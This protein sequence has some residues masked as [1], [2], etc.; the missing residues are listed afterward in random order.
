MEKGNI[1]VQTENIFP[2]IKKFLY[3]DQEIFLRE[4]ISNAVDATKKL[5]A[6]VSIGDFKGELG[7]LTIEVKLDEKNKTLSVIDK[8]I[9]MTA[10]E[11]KKYI[12]Q[13]AFSS[14]EDFVKKFKDKEEASTELIGHFGLGFYSG[15]MVADKV[16]LVTQSYKKV[17]AAKWTCDGSPAYTLDKH[18]KKDRGTEVTLYISDESKE[19][20]DKVRIKEL[21]KKYC[22]FLPVEIKFDG[23]IINNTTPA[24]TKKPTELT[25]QDYK[26]F[27]KELYPYAEEPLFWIHLNVDHPFWLTGILY[28]PKIKSTIEPQK[29][30]IQLYSNQVFV[31]DSVEGI[32]PEFLTLLHGVMDSPDI[33]LNVSRSFLQ[34]DANV[35]KINSHIMKK[36]ADKL[37][38][39]YKKDRKEYE[40]KWKD[41]GLF[42]KYGML[43]EEKFYER[44]NKFC[45]F[46][47]TE[48]KYFTIEEYKSKIKDAQTDKDKKL[49]IL[50]TTNPSEQ[51]SFIEA[52]RNKGYDVL[53]FDD[54]LD[55][56]FVG[57]LE[58]KFEDISFKRVDADT[59]DKLIDKDEK[60][61][62]AL[63]EK[64]KEQLKPI[65]EKQVN[66]SSVAILFE[67]LSEK[68]MPMLITKPESIRRM[69]DMAAIQGM[70]YLKD[71][72]EQFNL[73]VNTNHRLINRILIE[74]TPSNQGKLIKQAYDLAL[75]SQNMLQGADLTEFVNRSVE[76]IK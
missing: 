22:K 20:L 2:I 30:K 19:Y 25:S 39:L 76:L 7:E 13:I 56:H 68:D 57:F 46:R 62:S 35:K 63:T 5:K 34:S 69:K 9:G 52:A 53:Q 11:V 42:I 66:N 43:S 61:K 73:V 29:N 41:I 10:D 45:L 21:L 71:M 1:A 48:E 14:A 36:V 27:Y 50:Y 60:R 24:W 23:T 49:V 17:P 47:N 51:H 72:P 32:V 64:Q 12:N 28:F 74:K 65:I 33:P 16:E 54:M 15:F 67:G 26:N 38:E 40:E 31:T 75:I 44:A 8:G 3:S 55:S 6:L 18:D 70:D 4:L 58:G 59:V 37:E